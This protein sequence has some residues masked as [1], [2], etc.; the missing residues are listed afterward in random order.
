V[1]A[2]A[3]VMAAA[4]V[5]A[6]GEWRQLLCIITRMRHWRDIHSFGA[7]VPKASYAA[8]ARMFNP[9]RCC[10]LSSKLVVVACIFQLL[11]LRFSY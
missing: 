8:K 1:V 7:L 10:A 2:G 6:A 4:A 9:V 3:A 5:A 11:V